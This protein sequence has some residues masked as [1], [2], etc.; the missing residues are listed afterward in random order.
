MRVLGVDP[1]LTRC[2]WGVVDGRARAPAHGARRR[3]RPH[4]AATLT[5]SCGCSSSH[6]AVDG[7]GSRAPARRRGRRA[8][9]HASTTVDGDGHGAGRRGRAWP[10]RRPACRSPAHAERGQGGRSPATAAPTRTQVDDDGHPAARARRRRR[11]P[12]TPPT[13]SRSPICHMWRGPGRS[14]LRLA[15]LAGGTVRCADRCTLPRW[16]GNAV[17]AVSGRVAAIAPD[18]AVVEV[19]GVGM[20]VQCTPGTHRGAAD[21]GAGQAGHQPGRAGGLA[22][23]VRLR[24]RRRAPALRAAADRQRRRAA[25]RSGRARGASAPTRS[26]GRSPWPTSGR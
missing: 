8:G 14:R 18:G 2:G 3:R 20:A 10:P 25:A 7:A 23:P 9:L 1:G 6:T 16:T 22:D 17:I 19:G 12:P 26:G 21:R 11:S 4:P 13:R 15:S 24:L 5:W